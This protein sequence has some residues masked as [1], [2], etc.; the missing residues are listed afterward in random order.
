MT[1]RLPGRRN[2]GHLRAG[3]S[4]LAHVR[5]N[6]VKSGVRDFASRVDR[7]KNWPDQPAQPQAAEVEVSLQLRE[8]PEQ[9]L[10]WLSSD[11]HRRRPYKRRHNPC[12]Q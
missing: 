12:I 10:K 3:M 9:L 6:N 5:P 8:T 7:S 11:I 4:G 2:D 1:V